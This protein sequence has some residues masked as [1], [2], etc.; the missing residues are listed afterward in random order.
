MPSIQSWL[1]LIGVTGT[2][3]LM[4]SASVAMT[5]GRR[6]VRYG[7][8]IRADRTGRDQTAQIVQDRAQRREFAQVELARP[9]GRYPG[10]DRGA[11]GLHVGEGGIGGQDG[12]RPRAAGSQVMHVHGCAH[13]CPALADRQSGSQV[14]G[15][16]DDVPVP[17]FEASG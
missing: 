16:V 9:G 7:R 15:L 12:R 17:V 6:R 10:Y 11:F 3:A 5:A 8:P 4:A 2:A 1:P 13:T 14:D